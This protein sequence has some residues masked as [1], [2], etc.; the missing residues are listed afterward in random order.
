[1]LRISLLLP[2]RTHRTAGNASGRLGSIVSRTRI[3]SN[4]TIRLL[5]AGPAHTTTSVLRNIM[6][7]G[8][9]N[10]G[11]RCQLHLYTFHHISIST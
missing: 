3:P 10:G 8:M 1:M 11:L 7:T 9:V 4:A 6:R 5:A 2:S